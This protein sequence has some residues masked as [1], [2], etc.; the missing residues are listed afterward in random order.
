M[1]FDCKENYG[2]KN[3]SY[4]N[5]ALL[6]F[7]PMGRMCLLCPIM[8]RME[9]IKC[10]HICHNWRTNIHPKK[11]V[12]KKLILYETKVSMSSTPMRRMYLWRLITK[13]TR[14]LHASM[15]VTNW[16]TNIDS[17]KII[18]RKVLPMKPKHQCYLSRWGE[19][20]Y[21]AQAWNEKRLLCASMFVIIDGWTLIPKK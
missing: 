16:W 10:I 6:S 13:K 11:I 2:K 21:G 7:I 9:I 4:E 5:K 18:E 12:E 8:K 20:A 15:F 14:L 1:N 3:F 17:K 19:Y